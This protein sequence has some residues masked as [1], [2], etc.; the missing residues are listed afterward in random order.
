MKILIVPDVHGRKFWR[1][2]IYNNLH[3]VDKVIFLGDYLDPYRN[4]I[5]ESYKL[6]NMEC[7]DF[8]DA[9]NL[10]KMLNDIVSLKKNEPE[11]YILLTGNHTDSYIWSKFNAATRTD[12][13]N[14]ELYHKFFSQNLEFFNLVWVE[15]NVIFSHA[16]ITDGWAKE[17]WEK[18]RYPES[19]YKSIMDV[20]LA[21]SDIPLSN[22]NRE[23]IQLISNI[24]YYRWG[25][26]QYGSCEWADIREHI[27][28]AKT[29]ESNKIIPIGENGIYQVFGH[30]QV[31]SPIITEKWA[32]LDCQKGFIIDTL[33]K[34]IVKAKGY[35]ES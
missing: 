12:Y 11:K 24:S 35:Y 16:G 27:N 30:T 31:T 20:A 32:C 15:D 14:W 3:K 8:E 28:Q 17:V 9:Q 22:V 34:E 5:D 18:F 4:E 10:L 1:E 25:E 7:E 21:L 29:L 13:R 19:E 33:T 26:S 23:Y 2:T 6:H